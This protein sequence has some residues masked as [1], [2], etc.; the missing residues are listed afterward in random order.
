MSRGARP[1][2]SETPWT[3]EE[4]DLLRQLWIE[5]KLSTEQ[6][7]ARLGRTKSMVTGKVHRL[8]LPSRPSPIKRGVLPKRPPSPRRTG[9]W[10]MA[11]AGVAPNQPPVVAPAPLAAPK[12]CA[13]PIG[14]PGTKSF[15]FCNALARTGCP[16]C[17]EHAA[18]AY[19]R[20]RD[21]QATTKE[22]TP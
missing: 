16:Y 10:S 9:K 11:T 7:G 2:H 19:I 8:N 4:L 18:V 21:P 20:V 22:L 15:R 1:A 3:A 12:T 17:Q 5:G 6:I 14:E 13:W